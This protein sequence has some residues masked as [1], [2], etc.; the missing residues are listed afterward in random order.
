ML[1]YKV[2]LKNLNKYIYLKI[3]Y[4]YDKNKIFYWIIILKNNLKK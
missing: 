2:N 3:L 4:L 1:I